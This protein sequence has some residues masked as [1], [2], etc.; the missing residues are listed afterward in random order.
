MKKIVF[1]V[2][3]GNHIGIGH[4]MRCLTLAQELRLAGHEIFFITKNHIGFYNTQISILFSL[5]IL[6]NGIQ[7]ELPNLS[8]SK[9]SSW[10]GESSEADLEKTNKIISK[11]GP[12]DLVIIDH[13]ALDEKY[14]TGLQSKK[15][16]VI[17]DLMNRKH[18]CDILLD[19]NITADQFAYQKL[20]SKPGT[21]LLLGPDFALLR[22]EFGVRHKSISIGDQNRRINKILIFFGASDINND[23][24]KIAKALTVDVILYYELT[25]IL[26]ESHTSFSEVQSLLKAYPNIQLFPFVADIADLMFQSDL[27]IGAGGAT[28]WE[29]ASLGVASAI[30]SVAENQTRICEKLNRLEI[31]YYLGLSVQMTTEK[32]SEFFRDIVPDHSMWNLYRK[33]SFKLVDGL[34]TKKVS[35]H[36][37]KILNDLDQII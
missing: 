36:L 18:F 2:D 32:W 20:T 7:G 13:Y 12:V 6:E 8:K 33:N 5:H 19:Q 23:C 14:E 11:I 29:R 4:V 25:F 37:E 16:M 9:Y 15:V 34:G 35:K 24:L 3:S 22:D 26:N 27:F 31:A 30:V 28:S 21:I 1:R 17:D 10:L